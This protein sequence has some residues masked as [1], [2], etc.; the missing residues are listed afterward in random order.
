VRSGVAPLNAFEHRGINTAI[1]LDEAGIND[2]RDI[3]QEMRMVLRA[4]WV[5][6]MADEDVPSPGQVLR[7]ATTGGAA[8]TPFGIARIARLIEAPARRRRARAAATVEGPAAP[9]PPLVRRLFRPRGPPAL[10]P[11]DHRYDV[12][13]ASHVNSYRSWFGYLSTFGCCR[14]SKA[15]PS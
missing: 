7:M 1:G 4:H 13:I 15:R 11:S 6:G 10:L 9:C 2:Y 14:P 5:P 12:D 8:T 3:L